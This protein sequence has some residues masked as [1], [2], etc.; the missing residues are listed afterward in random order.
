VDETWNV[1]SQAASIGQYHPSFT[2]P[3]AAAFSLAGHPEAEA[4]LT[5]TLFF[6]WR[7]AQ[8]TQ[9]YLDNVSQIIRAKATHVRD[10]HRIKPKL[11]IPSGV[12][13]VDVRRFPPLHA[14]TRTDTP[15]L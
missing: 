7:V 10:Q 4:S 13:D 11:R 14:E 12:G 15:G 9:F 1:Y 8:N 6:G 3:Y 2:K 5:S